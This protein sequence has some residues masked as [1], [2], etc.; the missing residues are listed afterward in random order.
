MAGSACNRSDGAPAAEDTEVCS[1]RGGG[2]AGGDGEEPVS[3]F[4]PPTRRLRRLTI[5]LRGDLPTLEEYQ[6]LLAAPDPETWLDERLD[7]LLAAP[8]F[9]DRMVEMARHWVQLPP[10]VQ[11]TMA[12]AYRQSGMRWLRVCKE[13]TLH[14][15]H[16]ANLYRSVDCDQP[17]EVVEVEPWWAPGTTVTVVG[18]YANLSPRVSTPDGVVDCGMYSSDGCGCGPHLVYCTI[19]SHREEF[20]IRSRESPHRQLWEEPARLFA[21]IAWHDRPATDWILG[22]YTVGPKAAQSAYV[23][24]GRMALADDPG[25]ADALDAFD[26]WWRTDSWTAPTDPHH[27][28]TDPLAW[29]EFEIETRHP[30]L[31]S[32]RHV[33]YDPRVDDEE[34]FVGIPSAGM[35]TSLGVETNWSRERVRAARLLEVLACEQFSPPPADATFSPYQRDPDAEGPCLHCHNRIGPAAIHFKRFSRVG[36]SLATF[37]ILG[38]GAW[39]YPRRWRDGQAPYNKAPWTRM[40]RL[41]DHDMKMTPVTMDQIEADPDVTWIDFLPPDQT[42][43]GQTSDG[44]IGPLGFAKMVVASGAFDACLVRKVHQ[45]VVGRDLDPQREAGYLSELTSAFV[46]E[47]RQVRPLVRRLVES[48]PFRRGI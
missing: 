21:H 31:I 1:G 40:A 43:L 44:T 34:S 9:Y 19:Q 7:I 22:D 45:A 26:G 10:H 32:E 24:H 5:A 14:E 38:L 3:D 42:L 17:S 4:A 29:S 27:E 36:E 28:A 8:T 37:P 33:T 18:S 30:L 47:G 11:N 13:G 12:S 15:G 41:W 48:E 25:A 2:G 46:E 35:L 6:Q 39:Q 20:D 23:R 16:L